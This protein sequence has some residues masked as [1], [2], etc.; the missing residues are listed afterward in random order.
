MGK[1]IDNPCIDVCR[2]KGGVCVGCGRSRDEIK[3]WHGMKRKEKIL[4][5]KRARERLK[6]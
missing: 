6:R 4:V 2:L 1:G 3:R 5:Q